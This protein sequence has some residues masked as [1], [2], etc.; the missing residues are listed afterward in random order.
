MKL[1][2]ATRNPGKVRELSRLFAELEGVTVVGLDALSTPP[3]EV[4]ED[5]DTFEGNAI[6]KAAD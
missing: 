2:V 5:A 6:K 3:P 4:V 1:L